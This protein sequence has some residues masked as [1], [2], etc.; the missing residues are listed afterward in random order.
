[1]HRLAATLSATV[2]PVFFLRR[3]LEP[4]GDGYV[5]CTRSGNATVVACSLGTQAL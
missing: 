1:M 2:I 3:L 4:A 5:L